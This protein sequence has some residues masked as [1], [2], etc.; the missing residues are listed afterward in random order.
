MSSR[1]TAI[2]SAC[3][4]RS[5]KQGERYIFIPR[6][7]NAPWDFI[8]REI[9][10]LVA[11]IAVF[12]T[13][14][15]ADIDHPSGPLNGTTL[16][17]NRA[18]RL[19]ESIQPLRLHLTR[20]I[21]GISICRSFFSNIEF[22]PIVTALEP[23]AQIYTKERRHFVVDLRIGWLWLAQKHLNKLRCYLASDDFAVPPVIVF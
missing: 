2:C 14:I 10:R 18:C 4:F 7:R 20:K 9:I 5:D 19:V 12:R 16:G 3:G 21:R 1:P 6:C 13:F 15:G 11:I 8:L 22:R 23:L 17:N